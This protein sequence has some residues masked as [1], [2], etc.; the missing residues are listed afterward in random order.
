MKK[1]KVSKKTANKIIAEAKRLAKTKTMKQLF[2]MLGKAAIKK[3][4]RKK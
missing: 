3:N 4:R 2:A 1:S